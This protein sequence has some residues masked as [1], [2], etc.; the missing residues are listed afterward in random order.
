IHLP[1]TSLPSRCIYSPPPPIRHK[2]RR[3]PPTSSSSKSSVLPSLFLPPLFNCSRR[4]R[5][6]PTRFSR[7]HPRRRITIELRRAGETMAESS[8]HHHKLLLPLLA[9]A[10]SGE[11]DPK[12][13]LDVLV[14]AAR[15][16]E[17]RSA[18]ASKNVLPHVLR[19]IESIPDREYV[20]P[21]L[22]LLR[23]LCAGEA[24]NQNSFLRFN[25]AAA[26]ST[27]L[28]SAGLLHGEPDCAVVRTGLQ[29][30]ANVSLAGVEHQLAIWNE[31]FPEVF[32]AIGRVR[33]REIGDPLCMILYTCCDG[34]DGLVEQLLGEEG[35]PILAEILRTASSVG[36]Q[37]DW[38]KLV[39]SRICLDEN[40]FHSLFPRLYNVG[41]TK[42]KA[43]LV[44]NGINFSAEQAYLLQILSDILSD[45]MKELTVSS[46]FALCVLQ[47]FKNS[48]FVLLEHV[49]PQKSGL[50]TGSTS[51]DVLGYSLTVLKYICAIGFVDGVQDVVS[52]LLSN[53]L[54][55]MLLAI[56]RDLEPPMTIRKAMRSNEAS[57]SFAGKPCPYV[58]FRRDV[59]GVIGNCSFK[60][61]SVQ[62]EIRRDDGILLLLQQCVTDDDNPFLREW[63]IWA[64][65][66]LLEGNAENQE[67]VA[68][69]EIQGTVQ[70]PELEG[71]GLK[72][73][74][75]QKSGRARLVNTPPSSDPSLSSDMK[76]DI[77]P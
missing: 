58:G 38:L 53:G 55:D 1:Y 45:R 62:E 29:V 20:L 28:T 61:K 56:L 69:L 72:V 14:S 35:F 52:E 32:I 25:G 30:L 73:E 57:M 26:V 46:E 17:G 36:F 3:P 11:E 13:A 22:R 40:L 41:D 7:P 37:E 39:F 63:G 34:T 68:G 23:N 43:V 33:R 70:M 67:A 77:Q 2:L 42:S 51:I 59:V 76:V 47:I 12:E 10:S 8:L 18:L 15:S 27:V 9:V 16:D 21:C 75:D 66:N 60:R 49:P 64:V 65:R 44:E 50:P 24:S 5:I 6:P 31:F 54:L 71:L 48:T 74:V 4:R 19:F